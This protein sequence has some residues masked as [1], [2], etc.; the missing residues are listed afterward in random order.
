[1]TEVFVSI[2]IAGSYT[3]FAPGVLVIMENQIA[4]LAWFGD[5]FGIIGTAL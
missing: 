5:A 1:M 3:A 4:I 2:V